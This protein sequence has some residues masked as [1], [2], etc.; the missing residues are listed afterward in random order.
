P[1]TYFERAEMIQNVLLEAGIHRRNFGITPFPIESPSSLCQF[2]PVTV[3]VFTTIYDDW[4]RKKITILRD[5]GYEVQVLWERAQKDFVGM[6]V[7]NAVMD[8]RSDL[9]NLVPPS[10]MSTI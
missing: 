1:L 10:S 8:S 6:D 3:P 7:R 9:A 5:L 2:L 4:N